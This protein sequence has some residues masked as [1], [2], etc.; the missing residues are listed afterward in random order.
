M[1]ADNVNTHVGSIS[2]K[3]NIFG[4]AREI[5]CYLDA[6]DA[7]ALFER[8]S[9]SFKYDRKTLQFEESSWNVANPTHR[10]VIK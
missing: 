6:R 10:E 8:L 1:N 9:H 3:L 5:V 2:I 4:S 7:E